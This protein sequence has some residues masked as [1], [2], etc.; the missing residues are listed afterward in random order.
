MKDQDRD[1]GIVVC[2]LTPALEAGLVGDPDKADEFSAK[3]SMDLSSSRS[4]DQEECHRRMGWLRGKI[5][6]DFMADH[7]LQSSMPRIAN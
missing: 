5:D 2:N 7:G 4:C 6:L 3:V 1:V